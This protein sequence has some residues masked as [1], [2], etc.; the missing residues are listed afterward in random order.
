MYQSAEVQP[1]PSQISKIN[2]LR[3]YLTS[4]NQRC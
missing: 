4:L 2:L 1:R 3:E